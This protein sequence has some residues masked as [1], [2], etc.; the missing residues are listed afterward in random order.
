ME[1]LT[2]KR[3]TATQT[4]HENETKQHQTSW[5]YLNPISAS[6][7]P[8]KVSGHPVHS[9][10]VRV[11][12]LCG[13]QHHSIPPINVRSPDGLHLIIRPVHEAFSWVV[14]YGYGMADVTDLHE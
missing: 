14:V 8:V 6:V 11:F 3:H 13:N 2:T 9:N 7:G 10:T 4:V 1:T 12:E 5:I